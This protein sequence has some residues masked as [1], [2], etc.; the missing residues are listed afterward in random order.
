MSD[1]H[2]SW[3]K[4][5]FGVDLDQSLNRIKDEASAVID[6]AKNK[7]TQVVQGVQGAVEGAVDGVTSAAAGVVKKVAGAVAPSGSPSAGQGGGSGGGPGTFPL[8]GS[9]GRGGNNAPNDVRAVQAALGIGVDGQ[10]GGQTI[11][12]IETFQ[13]NMGQSKADGRVDVG[14]GTERALARGMKPSPAPATPD[15]DDSAGLLGQF[16]TGAAGLMSTNAGI[17]ETAEATLIAA[18]EVTGVSGAVRQVEAAASGALKTADQ[19]E[20]IVADDPFS[21]AVGFGFGAVQGV[22]PGGFLLPSPKPESKAFELG[23]GVGLIGGGIAAVAIGGGEEVVGTGLDVTGVGAVV[24]V[25]VNILGAVT[26][27][28]GVAAAGVGIATVG[29]VLATGGGGD[30]GEKPP[31]SGSGG[32]DFEKPI[33]DHGTKVGA[34][35]KNVGALETNLAEE[36]QTVTNDEAML[37]ALE[38]QKRSGSFDPKIAA[39]EGQATKDADLLRRTATNAKDVESVQA[40]VAALEKQNAGLAKDIEIASDVE[41]TLSTEKADRLGRAVSGLSKRL[42]ALSARTGVARDEVISLQVRIQKL[43]ERLKK[44]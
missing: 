42:S 10:C 14:G 29:G 43:G 7:V 1:E 4:D 3:F 16:P 15:G 19:A 2:D 18:G 27:A 30:G 35:E 36:T 11:A 13:R 40:E 39:L 17:L 21:A 24:G 25:P 6:D 38:G 12:A 31:G 37:D 23:R 32:A 22:A 28:S 26:I 33:S 44:L 8:G 34:A 9:V 20:S 5:A 41:R